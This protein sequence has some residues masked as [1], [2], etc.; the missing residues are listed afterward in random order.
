MGSFANLD[1]ERLTKSDCYV[2]KR[3]R[4]KIIA[5]AEAYKRKIA[6]MDKEKYTSAK[7]KITSALATKDSAMVRGLGEDM[8]GELFTNKAAIN[9]YD[10][11]IVYRDRDKDRFVF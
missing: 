9:R 2:A 8:G 3:S 6:V 10:V 7:D 4:V 5:L 11:K 1:E